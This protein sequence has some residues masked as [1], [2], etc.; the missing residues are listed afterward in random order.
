MATGSWLTASV[1]DSAREVIATAFDEAERRDP[2]HLRPWVCL[3][4]GA[5]HQSDVIAAGAR[6]RGVKV[7]IVCDFI[8]VLE[9]LWGAAWCFFDEGDPVA[10]GWVAEKGLAVLEGRAGLVAGAIARKATALGLAGPKPKKADECTR[11]F[12][13]K[14]VYLDYPTAL[15]EGWPIATGV[16]ERACR[17]LVRDRFDITGARWS[18]EAAEAMVKLRAV[19]TNGDGEAYGHHHLTAERERVHAS[20][21]VGGVIPAAA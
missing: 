12:K 17:H 6:R 5:K 19:R 10:A 9:Y 16:I 4:D 21:Y 15:A 20:R 1:V 11:S 7:T 3:V 14:R 2:E 13:N 18:L 8:H